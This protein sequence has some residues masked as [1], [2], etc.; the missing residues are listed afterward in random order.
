MKKWK[1]ELIMLTATVVLAGVIWWVVSTHDER[2][3]MAEYRQLEI[4]AKR[5][6]VEIAIIKQATELQKLRT[7]IKQAQQNQVNSLP[8]LQNINQPEK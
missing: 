4:F 2:N 3:A 5:Q 1:I 6:A 8:G 7:A